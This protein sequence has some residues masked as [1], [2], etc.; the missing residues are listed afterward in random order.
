MPR[1]VSCRVR[2]NVKARQHAQLFM[3]HF[4]LHTQIMGPTHLRLVKPLWPLHLGGACVHACSWVSALPDYCDVSHLACVSSSVQ[5]L[6]YYHLSST[7]AASFYV[8]Q[9][10]LNR[11]SLHTVA[12]T[13]HPAT[14]MGCPFDGAGMPT[15]SHATE[16]HL[17]FALASA[18]W[19]KPSSSLRLEA[20]AAAATDGPDLCC[21]E[22]GALR[23][24]D[25]GGAVWRQRALRHCSCGTGRA[26]SWPS[27]CV[28]PLSTRATTCGCSCCCRA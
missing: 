15:W 1:T 13:V 10:E 4:P 12:T 8:A 22:G 19:R 3:I 11:Q 6:S 17:S 21:V 26:S 14:L 28:A 5:R 25:W 2:P 18:V 27:C 9:G 7:H 24:L 23:L 16:F 20:E